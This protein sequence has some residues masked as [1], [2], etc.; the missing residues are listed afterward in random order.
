MPVKS[1]V[2]MALAIAATASCGKGAVSAADCMR[3]MATVACPPGTAPTSGSVGNST[4][5]AAAAANVTGGQLGVQTSDGVTCNYHCASICQ[6]GIERVEGDGAVVCTP[7]FGA[8]A[9]SAVTAQEPRV[10]QPSQQVVQ[11]N[12]QQRAAARVTL[13]YN[14]PPLFE[15]H[16]LTAP[17]RPDPFGITVRAGGNEAIQEAGVID[18]TGGQCRGFVNAGQPDIAITYTSRGTPL[19]FSVNS[20]AD[21]TLI[22]SLPDGSWRCNDDANANT[23]NPRFHFANGMSGRYS[24]WVG[25]YNRDGTFPIAQ[26]RATTQL[27]SN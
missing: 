9:Q 27:G 18:P 23:R 17:F 11:Q 16:H 6:C 1:L 4:V 25:T 22:V 2:V 21:T 12:Q 15:H 19:T 26:F 10:A 24:V 3:A 13:N 14:Q 7:C 5:N 20:E 8:L